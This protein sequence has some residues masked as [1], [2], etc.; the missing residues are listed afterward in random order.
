VAAPDM[1]L[2]DPV[3]GMTVDAADVRHTAEHDGITYA[4]CCAPC[5]RQ[6]T[7]NPD[8]FLAEA[9]AAEAATPA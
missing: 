6:F 8:A 9:L 2:V 1:V 7:K 5:R 4:F 3:C